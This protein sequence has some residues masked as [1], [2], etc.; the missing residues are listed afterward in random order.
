LGHDAVVGGDDDDHNVSDLSAAG[1]HAGEGFVAGG[2]EEDDLAAGCR[3]AFLGKLHLVGADVLGDAAGLAFGHV[4]EADGVEQ[5]GL[6]VI[7][8]AHDGDDGGT[9]DF[10]LAGVFGFEDLFD[11][12]VGDLFFVAD[13]VGGGA[14]FG[15]HVL[16]HFGVEG[17]VDG[18]EDAAHQERGNQVLGADVELFG[19]VLDADAFGYGDFASDGQRFTA[20]LHPA[21]TRRRHK[22][23]MGPSLVLGYCGRPPRPLL[24]AARWGGALRRLVERRRARDAGRRSHRD[25]LRQSRAVRRNRDARREHQDR[26]CRRV[27]HSR[28]GWCGWDAWAAVRRAFGRASQRLPRCVAD[29][30]R[31][32]RRARSKIGLPR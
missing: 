30:C 9:G 3:R 32:R 26:Q 17:L 27:R 2:V 28:Q 5:G 7:D 18:D 11:G 8:V 20:I 6:A 13:D 1:S 22:A 15:G 25:G 31:A 10:E 19:Q 23:F 4:R 12:L 21:V 29:N 14:E 24:G 16:D